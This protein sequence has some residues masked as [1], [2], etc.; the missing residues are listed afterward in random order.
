M[1]ITCPHCKKKNEL[2]FFLGERDIPSCYACSLCG[3]RV[4]NPHLVDEEG[5]Y[6]SG[7]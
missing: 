5:E 1:A 6:A 2:K 7:T 3:L 4:D